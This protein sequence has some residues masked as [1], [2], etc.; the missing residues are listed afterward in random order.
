[1]YGIVSVMVAGQFYGSGPLVLTMM[2]RIR[3]ALSLVPP[4]SPSGEMQ[5][6]TG[7][8]TVKVDVGILGKMDETVQDSAMRDATP[9]MDEMR[10]LNADHQKIRSDAQKVA[11]GIERRIGA[12]D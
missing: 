5:L 4:T 11:G 12:C 6:A 9:V 10:N 7:A 8:S 2:K 1:M 3:L